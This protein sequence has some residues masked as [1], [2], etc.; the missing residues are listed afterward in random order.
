M[1][2]R[3]TNLLESRSRWDPQSHNRNID[4]V[5]RAILFEAYRRERDSQNRAIEEGLTE[6]GTNLQNNQEI[7]L[8][9]VGSNNVTTINDLI[10]DGQVDSLKVSE[11]YGTN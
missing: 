4:A 7:D 6:L 2:Y 9:M 11:T 1:V 10:L 3:I 8:N 5:F